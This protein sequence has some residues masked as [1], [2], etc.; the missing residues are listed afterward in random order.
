MRLDQAPR[1]AF[2]LS[3]VLL[4]GCTDPIDDLVPTRQAWVVMGTTLEI[5]VYR[6]ETE[7]AASVD[8]L[9]AAYAEVVEIDQLMSLYRGD[10]EL[11]ALNARAG[12][13]LLPVSASTADVLRASLHYADLTGSALDVTVQPLVELWGF[14]NVSTAKVPSRGEIE[15]VMQRIGIDRATLD[16]P[17]RQVALASNTALD[18][19]GVAKGYAV[20]RAVEAL[21]T[22]G[23]S[24]GLVNLGGNVS[25]F[26]QAE[27]GRP[28]RIGIRH[29][30]ENRLI[31]RVNLMSGAVAT[32]GDYDRYFE[33]EGKRYSHILDPRTGWPVEDIYAVTVVAPN[34]TTAD[35]LSTAAFVMGE[36][37]GMDLLSRCVGVEGV[38][39]QPD[40]DTG[41]LTAVRAGSDGISI[42]IDAVVT[43][44][45][46]TSA[47][48]KDVTPIEGCVWSF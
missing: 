1:A 44:K 48:Y 21:K 32:S 46:R 8:D 10:S 35:A 19:G 30:R 29:P 23:V 39:I 5:T 7:S 24:A 26:G 13:G 14:Y 6:P 17:S 47:G 9:E 36:K 4:L 38:L 31:G 3:I 15:S 42:E 27:A 33:F 28:W 22:R 37:R 12:E 18:F 11:S 43:T 45:K 2:F 25:V 41:V 34:A 20:D 16:D 40:V